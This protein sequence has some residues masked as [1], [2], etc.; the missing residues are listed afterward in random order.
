LPKQ[1]DARPQNAAKQNEAARTLI[2]QRE[3]A[4]DAGMSDHQ[5]VQAVRVA[6]VPAKTFKAAVESEAPPSLASSE[7][8]APVILTLG[9]RCAVR[10]LA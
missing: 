7:P 1:F 10:T 9:L 6:N 8:R 2:S 5:R 4:R 3:V